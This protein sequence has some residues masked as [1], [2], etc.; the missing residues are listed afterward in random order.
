MFTELVRDEL[1]TSEGFIVNTLGA[2]DKDREDIRVVLCIGRKIPMNIGG[3]I[4]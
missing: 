2:R 3:D 4:D 1:G